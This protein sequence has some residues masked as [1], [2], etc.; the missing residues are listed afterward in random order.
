MQTNLEKE[1]KN[2]TKYKNKNISSYHIYITQ[3]TFI[4]ITM[5]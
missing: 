2:R 5:D 1:Y 4:K 3:H